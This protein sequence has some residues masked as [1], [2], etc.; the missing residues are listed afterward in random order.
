MASQ[1]FSTPVTAAE[2]THGPAVAQTLMAVALEIKD[3]AR[4]SDRLQSLISTAL[5]FD[6]SANA[7]HVREF[8][9][10]DLLVQRLHGVA[11]FMEALSD[12]APL[13]WRLSAGDACLTRF[14]RR[15]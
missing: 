13:S 3:L 14:R 2:D 7:D 1:A 15:C 6:G 4:V 8:Q 9:A 11:I 5:V 12:L 10:I